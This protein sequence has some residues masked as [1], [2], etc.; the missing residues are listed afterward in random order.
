MQRESKQCWQPSTNRLPKCMQVVKVKSHQGVYL[1]KVTDS[2]EEARE[3]GAAGMS[4]QG[5]HRQRP[6]THL[7]CL[8]YCQICHSSPSSGGRTLRMKNQSSLLAD[9]NHHC[10]AQ[11]QLVTTAWPE[12][13]GD[14]CLAQRQLVQGTAGLT[15]GSTQG[16]RE[17]YPGQ[18]LPPQ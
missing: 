1:N 14:H 10:L 12:A 5:S 13:A 2:D 9:N 11:R 3:A 16:T 15:A 18:S 7:S 8:T 17:S 6:L 4:Q